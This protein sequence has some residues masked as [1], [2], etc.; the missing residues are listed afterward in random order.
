MVVE[1]IKKIFDVY[2][3]APL[4]IWELFY[5]KLSK[6]HFTKNEIIKRAGEKERFLNII[7]KGSAGIFINTDNRQICIDLC[8][9]NDFFCDNASFLSQKPTE[10]FTQALEE[11]SMLSIAFSDLSLL[12][13]GSHIGLTIG[14]VAAEQSYI[15]KQNQQIDL[16][17]LT[18]EKR[19]L[20]LLK[21]QA[22][23]VQRVPQK[24]IASY[25]GITPESF[26][27]I[28]KQ[29]FL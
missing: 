17:S 3:E 22:N 15:H 28:R 10:I 20:N 5:S 1:E 26:S 14:K 27:R 2:F 21:K 25:L 9:E 7:S 19:Y 16:L 8:F 23:I 12:Y 29:I 18:A 13:K 6:R 24:Q 11:V 4:E